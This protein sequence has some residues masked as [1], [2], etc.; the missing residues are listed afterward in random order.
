MRRHRNPRLR[1]KR[2]DPVVFSATVFPPVFGPLIT[3]NRSSPPSAN[4]IGTIA[5]FSRRKLVFSTGCLAASSRNSVLSANSGTHASKSRA[6]RAL[7][8]HCR[9]PQS[10]ANL[11]GAV[12]PA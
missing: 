4:D 12:H 7:A 8:R 5:R 1:R 2:R 9:V 6:N 11:Q 10:S 3:S